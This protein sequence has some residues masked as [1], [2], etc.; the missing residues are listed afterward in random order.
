[1]G[2]AL[3]VGV[4]CASATAG[5][6]KDE[7]RRDS[8]GVST[9]T[10]AEPAAVRLKPSQGELATLL[11]AETAKARAKNLKPY[12]EVR[13]DWCGPCKELEASMTDPRMVDAFAGTYV[14]RLDADEW[15]GKLKAF[16]LES[17]SIPV[18]FEIDDTGKATGRRIDGGA[19]ADNIPA[20]MAPP[21]KS[22]FAK[23]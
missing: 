4:L 19:W 3:C 5:C 22:F 1:V 16:G 13:A 17:S 9:T 7:A 8:A 21:L 15:A 11:P 18:F 14:I 23:K 2:T 6:K 12:V 10:G 20:N